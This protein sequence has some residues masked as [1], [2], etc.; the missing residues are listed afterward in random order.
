MGKKIR[1]RLLDGQILLQIGTY[2]YCNNCGKDL[3]ENSFIHLNT[4]RLVET[5]GL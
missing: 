5:K 4:V 2:Q 3:G 1:N